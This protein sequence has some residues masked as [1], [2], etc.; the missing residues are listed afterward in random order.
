M[1]LRAVERAVP[2]A[3]E[4]AHLRAHPREAAAIEDLFHV[5]THETESQLGFVLQDIERLLDQVSVRERYPMFRYEEVDHIVA[6]GWSTTLVRELHEHHP[7]VPLRTLSAQVK[8]LCT[9][10]G[11]LKKVSASGGQAPAAALQATSS[12]TGVDR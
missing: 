7:E 5:A 4:N 9:E 3:M 2:Q 11:R 8:G 12:N 6:A 10:W 1:L